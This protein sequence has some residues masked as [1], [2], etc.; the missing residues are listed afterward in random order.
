MSFSGDIRRR[1]IPALN[2]GK[3]ASLLPFY[4][5]METVVQH[6]ALSVSEWACQSIYILASHHSTSKSFLIFA[7]S[8]NP[9][10]KQRFIKLCIMFPCSS[11]N[12]FSSVC[13]FVH[14][15]DIK[16]AATPEVPLQI[17]FVCWF[18]C[19]WM[20]VW[21]RVVFVWQCILGV[22]VR[23]IWMGVRN[24]GLWHHSMLMTINLKAKS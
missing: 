1:L 21:G 3:Q 11:Q 20:Y 2:K 18:V 7:Q 14:T 9:Q 10:S 19:V 6:S 13:V 8:I 16:A 15:E 24:F 12:L 17:Y 5:C 22:N 4:G 23:K